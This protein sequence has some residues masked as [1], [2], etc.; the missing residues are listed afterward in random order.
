MVGF[1]KSS[2]IYIYNDN[3]VYHKWGEIHWAKHSWFQPYE[4]FHRNICCS[5]AS[6][7]YYLTIAKYPQENFRGTLKNHEN[8]GS[9]AQ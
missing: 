9:L 4:D 7:I 8:H 2:H 3:P 6:S 1:P 5:L